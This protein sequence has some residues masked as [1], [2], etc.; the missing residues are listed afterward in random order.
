MTLRDTIIA[1]L[2]ALTDEPAAHADRIVAEIER[3]VTALV[4]PAF[5][6]A[7]LARDTL[8]R[9]P[10]HDEAIVQRALAAELDPWPWAQWPWSPGDISV[11]EIIAALERV[12]DDGARAVARALRTM[13]PSS[14]DALVLYADAVRA[15]DEAG[16]SGWDLTCC[17]LVLSARKDVEASRR[18]PA[19]RM[20]AKPPARAV[21]RVLAEGAPR[22]DCMTHWHDE[23]PAPD[24]YE[25]TWWGRQQPVQ[26]RLL[27]G[28]PL[29]TSLV[30]AIQDELSDD[31]VRDWLTLHVM[32]ERQGG[33][34]TI[35]WTWTEHREIAGYARQRASK[36]VRTTD[37]EQAAACTRRL[38][39]LSRARI[40]V[41]YGTKY[42]WSPLI[43][44]E[45][46]GE[47]DA[48]RVAQIRFGGPLYAGARAGEREPY[49]ALVPEAIITM[50]RLPRALGV[51]L[52]YDWRYARDNG[53]VVV[54]DA[55]TLWDYGRI[56]GGAWERRQQWPRARGVLEHA[57]D[58]LA[59]RVGLAWRA[60]PDP[61]HGLD[62]P[63]TRYII[64]P[65]RW[66]QDRVLHGVTPALPPS[67]AGLPRTGGELRAWRERRGLTQRRVGAL[68]GVDQATVHR[69][70]RMEAQALP[71]EWVAKLSSFREKK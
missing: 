50:P 54:R 52:A 62:G 16:V 11:A 43:H 28:E 67:T 29:Q 3:Y 40:R 48:L 60:E 65:P 56:L 49:Y 13:R 33:S 12:P 71:A 64:T 10:T 8:A 32:A 7:V 4:E 39:L 25:L 42:I 45:G 5:R 26:L 57:L 31:G 55:R 36:N 38:E 68:L 44:A 66:W 46:I 35:R 30:R 47:G 41:Y 59:A 20:S 23:A 69:A 37:A 17:A 63:A 21:V 22:K 27:A 15:R 9:W 14:H 58:A 18:R 6:D 70:E 34:G 19:V 24:G 2:R 53:G 61:E 1:S 51:L